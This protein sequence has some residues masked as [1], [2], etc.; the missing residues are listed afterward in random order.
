MDCGSGL[1]HGGKT[2]EKSATVCW[3]KASGVAHVKHV[4]ASSGNDRDRAWKKTTYFHGKSLLR[5]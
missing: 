3:I 2:G 4:H 5:L 1:H